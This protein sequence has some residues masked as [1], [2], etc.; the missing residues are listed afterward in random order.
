MQEYT[1]LKLAEVQEKIIQELDDEWEE[2]LTS[3]SSR[4]PYSGQIFSAI[5]KIGL[6]K[7]ERIID[8]AIECEKIAILRQAQIFDEEYFND[9]KKDIIEIADDILM[10]IYSRQISYLPNPNDPLKN[11]LNIDNEQ[12][13]SKFASKINNKINILKEEIKL[14]ISLPH[15][16]TSI[17][18]GGDVGVLNIGNVYGSINNEIQKIQNKNDADIFNKFLSAIKE[19]DIEDNNKIEHMEQVEVLIEQYK[20]PQ[21]KRKI[22]ITK[23]VLGALNAAANLTT[24]WAQ[25]GPAL[26]KLFQG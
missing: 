6:A 3:I 24:V 14:K 8:N 19:S 10:D 11:E 21:E 15:V 1:K 26:T 25:W 7:L 2:A 18:V 22:G 12:N 20:L 16:G 5:E 9:F 13:K 17:T 4:L 23:A